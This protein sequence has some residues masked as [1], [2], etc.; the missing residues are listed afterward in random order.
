[1]NLTPHY[2]DLY[3]NSKAKIASEKY[4]VDTLMDSDLDQ[5]FGITLL[6]RPPEE[7]K[8]AA[9]FFLS[10]LK[11]VEPQQYYY[12]NSDIHITV[13]SIIS[14]YDGFKLSSINLEDYIEIVEKCIIKNQKI[15]INFKGV[16]ASS[17]CVML[18]GHM[19]NSVLNDTRNNLRTAFKNSN[20]EQSIDARYAIQTAHSTVVRFKEKL[21]QK[22]LFL[23]TL[24]EYLHYDF[25]T[26]E[27]NNF[28]LVFNDWYQRAKYVKTLHQFK[29][30]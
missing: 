29:C 27:V 3:K 18:Q 24:D 15:E 6:I 20:L 7:I 4:D 19:N 1:M 2:L 13:M 17:S 14:C 12:P 23:Q 9:Q 25:G 28:E 21:K 5:R 8:N 10:K 30:I 22:E 26:F 16:T 11:L